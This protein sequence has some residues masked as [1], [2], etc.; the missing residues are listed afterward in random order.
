MFQK[1]EFGVW[2]KNLKQNLP[3]QGL[4]K[5]S[6]TT[7]DR[8]LLRL[9]KQ[10]RTKTTQESS[11]ELMLSNGKKLS[12]RTVCRRLLDVRYK[13]YTAKSKPFREPEHKKEQLSFTKEHQK[14]LND[15]NNIIWS[16]K[17]HF[18]VFNRK[19]RTFVGRSKADSNQSVNFLPR[20]QGG[21]EHVSIWDCMSGVARSLLAMYS[22]KVNGLAYIKIIEE[23]LPTF[24]ENTFDSSNK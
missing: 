7:D 20:V 10:D 13:S 2:Q 21:G 22:G 24:I 1:H 6:T 5:A 23:A 15:W 16:D 14:W 9:C 12:T 11:S 8:N 17:A 18:E 19:N 3:F 4:K